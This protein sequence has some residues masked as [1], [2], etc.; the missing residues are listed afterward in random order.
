MQAVKRP[1]KGYRSFI[2]SVIH[3]NLE[4]AAHCNEEL[5]TMPVRMRAAV[6][7]RRNIVYYYIQAARKSNNKFRLFFKCM[8]TAFL[9]ARHVIDPIRALNLKGDITLLFNE[10]KISSF[11]QHFWKLYYFS[12]F[13]YSE[14]GS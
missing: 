13:H 7:A 2:D 5:M 11:I 1:V 14:V 8:T 3:F 6:F 4:A 10:G 12:G 9:S